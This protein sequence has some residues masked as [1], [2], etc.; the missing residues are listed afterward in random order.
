[1]VIIAYLGGNNYVNIYPN[2]V[3]NNL[4]IEKQN[5]SITNTNIVITDVSGK[6][7]YHNN[8]TL[9]TTLNIETNTWSRGVYFVKVN[10]NEGSST[11]KIVKE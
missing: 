4:F 6:V 11:I 9:S 5:G 7:V 10:S 3:K 1:M 2:P 8:S